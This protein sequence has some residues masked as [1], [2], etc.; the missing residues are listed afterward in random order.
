MS[1]ATILQQL[2]DAMADVSANIHP[3][4][5][6]LTD[7]RGSIGAG[8]IW[9][10]DGL[11]ITNAHVVIERGRHAPSFRG[12]RRMNMRQI[13]NLSATLADGR[14]LPVQVIAIDV[15]HDLAALSIDA[16]DLSTIEIGDSQAVRAGDWVMAMGHP[17]GVKDSLTAG[18]VISVGTDLPEMHTGREWLAL[19][20]R[21]RP[22]HSGGPL[23]D[24][25]GKIIGINTLITGPEVG[26]AV[27]VET[28]K[29]FLKDNL[30]A[31]VTNAI[32]I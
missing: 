31:K 11:I 29:T 27:P 4:L 3:S 16:N 23:V 8:T 1:D 21:L 14:K 12:H 15:Q 6:Q 7:D 19:D 30:G 24:V 26:F 10:S 5:V 18:V 2:S 13:R 9:H 28:V 17:W 22:G 20:L 25:N 32:A